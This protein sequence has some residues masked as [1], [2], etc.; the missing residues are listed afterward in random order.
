MA[1]L[2]S[3]YTS[4]QCYTLS[5]YITKGDIIQRAGESECDTYLNICI[6]DLIDKSVFLAYAMRSHFEYEES[7]VQ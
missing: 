1:C 7:F 6:H 3:S 4:D 2:N 5:N